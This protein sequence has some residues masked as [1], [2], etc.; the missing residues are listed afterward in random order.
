MVSVF[1]SHSSQDKPFVRM[2]A[3]ALEAGE[4]IKVWLDEIG[5]GLDA[6]VVLLI[7]SPD[8]VDSNWVKDEWTDAHWDQTNSQRTKLAGV[9][10]R[11]C[12]I[13]RLLRNKKYF[14][15]RTNF[16]SLETNWHIL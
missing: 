2:L 13:P 8:S 9:L 4:E 10:Y 11:E 5:Q 12:Q 6:D 14:D 16:R 15:L 7:L 1:L 3:D